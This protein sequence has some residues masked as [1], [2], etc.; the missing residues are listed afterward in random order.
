MPGVD[1]H[2]AV[3]EVGVD[4]RAAGGVDRLAATPLDVIVPP[5]SVSPLSM[6][7]IPSVSLLPATTS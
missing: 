3:V 2:G 4:G 7:W 1:R 6:A 5:F